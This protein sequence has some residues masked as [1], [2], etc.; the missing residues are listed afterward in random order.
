M[1]ICI[2]YMHLYMY[3]VYTYIHINEIGIISYLWDWSLHLS[4]NASKKICI[5]SFL[6]DRKHGCTQLPFLLLKNASYF[7]NVFW[8]V[9]TLQIHNIFWLISVMSIYFYL[10]A[11]TLVQ[12]V[13]LTLNV[14]ASIPSDQISRLVLKP[15][16]HLF[17]TNHVFKN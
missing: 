11:R 2:S 12:I 16:T 15:N 1:C 3:Y 8:V 13:P 4:F 14:L 5:K 7:F 6:M 17:T 10:F 9:F